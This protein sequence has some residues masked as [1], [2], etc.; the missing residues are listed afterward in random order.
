MT[1]RLTLAIL[2]LVLTIFACVWIGRQMQTSAH[3]QTLDSRLISAVR[4][5]DLSAAAR[6]LDIGAN[7]NAREGNRLTFIQRLLMTL[8]A[9]RFGYEQPASDFRFS[10]SNPEALWFAYIAR[11]NDM[12][13]LLL[14]HG[15][16]PNIAFVGVPP[17]LDIVAQKN[18]PML[19]T[20]LDSGAKANV[21]DAQK[22][23][24]A[25]MSA[26]RR[27]QT[28]DM[29]LLLDSG[30]NVNVKNK[31]GKTALTLAEENKRADAVKLLRAAGGTH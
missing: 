25:L 22:G 2:A 19:K 29:R 8:R 5:N 6:L 24:T 9:R 10:S 30:A 16:N 27:G 7:P 4:A 1:K 26:A 31:A 3:Q 13:A 20:F 17:L 12:A 21:T 11:Q 18:T 15:A 14:K 23:M 28:R